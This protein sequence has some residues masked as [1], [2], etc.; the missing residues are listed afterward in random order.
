MQPYVHILVLIFPKSFHYDVVFISRNGIVPVVM[1]AKKSSYHQV[2]PPHSFIH[3]DDFISPTQLAAHMK[4]LD[5]DD[6]R[7]NSYFRWK[8]DYEIIMRPKRIMFCHLCE[9]LYSRSEEVGWYQDFGKWWNGK[10]VC[11]KSTLKNPYASW[12]FKG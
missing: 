3:V 8:L 6:L 10:G 12:K 9:L 1:G 7:Y 11:S 4:M 5:S 2:A